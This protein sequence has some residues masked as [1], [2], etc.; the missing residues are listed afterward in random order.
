MTVRRVFF[1]T[2]AILLTLA[3]LYA[4]FGIAYLNGWFQPWVYRWLGA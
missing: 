1:R 2:T 3:W 4:W